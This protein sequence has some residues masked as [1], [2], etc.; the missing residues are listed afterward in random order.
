MRMTNH[1][2]WH[3]CHW[4]ISR[5]PAVAEL[6]VL[7]GM[8]RNRR[9][10]SPQLAKPLSRKRD[11][12]SGKEPLIC[13]PPLIV[14][15]DVRV[16]LMTG[17]RVRVVGKAIFDVTTQKGVGLT[18]EFAHKRS[19]PV[20]RRDTVIVDERQEPTAR[21][22]GARASRRGGAYASR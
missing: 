7:R 15:S 10:K 1:R 3:I 5:P 17:G 8:A 14:L 18:S 20:R 4:V 22:R 19:E 11:V 13:M 2:V 6:F 9:V 12:V 16:D 21:Y